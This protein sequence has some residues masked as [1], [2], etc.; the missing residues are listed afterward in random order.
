MEQR[1]AAEEDVLLPNISKPLSIELLLFLSIT[2][3]PSSF[4]AHPVF[5]A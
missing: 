4:P 1:L 5:S 2:K 3:N